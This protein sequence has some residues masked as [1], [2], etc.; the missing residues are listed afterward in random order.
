MTNFTEQSLPTSSEEVADL[1]NA[2]NIRRNVR[3]AYS[4]AARNEGSSCS[5]H[6][7]SS[8]NAPM[9]PSYLTRARPIPSPRT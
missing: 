7:A 9:R 4:Q 5:P 3:E 1:A 6:S 2:G 8:T